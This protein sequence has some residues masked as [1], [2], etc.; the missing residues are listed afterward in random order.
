MG[1][2]DPVGYAPLRELLCVYLR[3]SRGVNCTPDQ[4]IITSGSQ[5]G[6]YLLAQL[7]LAPGD[8]VWAES[9]GYQ[10]ASAPFIAIAPPCARCRWTG[11]AWTWR[12]PCATTRMRS[13][14]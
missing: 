12:S 13:W 1:Y 8:K 7:L 3:A 9:P 10:G 4:I 2:S 6:L 14:S 11:R 5:Q